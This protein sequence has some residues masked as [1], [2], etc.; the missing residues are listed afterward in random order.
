MGAVAFGAVGIGPDLPEAVVNCPDL[1]VA[2]VIWLLSVEKAPFVMVMPN[3]LSMNSTPTVGRTRP[4]PRAFVTACFWV[5]YS[6]GMMPEAVG[7]DASTEAF[8]ATDHLRL[9]FGMEHGNGIDSLSSPSPHGVMT[10]P[11][12]KEK[13]HHPIELSK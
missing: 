1:P 9:G 6:T 13:R 5:S 7:V 12:V 11:L 2:V 3:S 10:L 8:F 4:A